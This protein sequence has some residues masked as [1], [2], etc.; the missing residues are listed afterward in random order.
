MLK[1]RFA[2]AVTALILVAPTGLAWAQSL[3]ARRTAMG[4]VVLPGG[5]SGSE[6]SNVAYRAVEKAPGRST[7]LPLPIGLIPLLSNPP[8]FDPNSADF[9]VFELA[10]LLYNPPWNIQLVK[11]KEPSNDIVMSIGKNHMSIDLGDIRNMFPQDHSE[12]GASVQ[13]PSLGF[14]IKNFFVAGSALVQ[15]HND[16]SMNRSLYSVLHDAAELQPLTEYALYDG[17]RGQAAA[18]VQLGW[19]GAVSKSGDPRKDGSAFY[20]GARTKI[21]RG[22]AYADAQNEVSFTTPDTLFSN[23]PVNLNYSAMIRDAGPDGGGWGRGLD[24]GF[25]WLAQGVEFGVGV[26]DIATR[27]DW[28]VKESVTQ[29]D[30]VTGDYSRQTIAEDVP[31]SSEVSKTVTTNMAKQFGRTLVAA[32]VVRSQD[33][34]TSH[35]GTETW[36]GIFALRTGANIDANHKLQYSGGTGVRL[37]PVGLDLAVASHSRNLAQERGVEL[38]AALSLYR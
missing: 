35:F 6:G 33:K 18:M 24:L 26:N 15:Y 13:G 34:T 27:I 37:G 29:R 31:F 8:S 9:N 22:L 1:Y 28:K 21:L 11:P 30:S 16:L 36:V 38:G 10:N 3:N 17:V 7:E 2:I 14:G 19:A 4:G 20:V 25:V 32:D 5:G 12:F 23:S